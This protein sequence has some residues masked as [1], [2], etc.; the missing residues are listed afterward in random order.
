MRFHEEQKSRTRFNRRKVNRA[1]KGVA[2]LRS[3]VLLLVTQK[4]KSSR[5]DG[6]CCCWVRR[7]GEVEPVIATS[8][9]GRLG[10]GEGSVM[11]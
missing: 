10:C 11:P 5:C 8:K 7:K 2:P 9:G 1:R 6:G 3:W 4:G